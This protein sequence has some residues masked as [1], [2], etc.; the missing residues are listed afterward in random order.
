MGS[1]VELS[2]YGFNLK[3]AIRIKQI[4]LGIRGEYYLTYETPPATDEFDNYMGFSGGAFAEYDFIKDLRYSLYPFVCLGQTKIAEQNES[5]NNNY[6]GY[7]IYYSIGLGVDFALT[8]FISLGAELE[9]MMAPIID[10][11]DQN[12]STV[13]DRIVLDGL[14]AGITLKFVKQPGK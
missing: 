1:K 9:Y 5:S 10:I 8:K 6:A 13:V 2:S 3:A 7:S 12:G 4:G 11:D 14:W